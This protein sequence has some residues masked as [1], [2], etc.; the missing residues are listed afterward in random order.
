MPS[1]NLSLSQDPGYHTLADV[2]FFTPSAVEKNSVLENLPWYRLEGNQGVAFY[3]EE[4]T[5]L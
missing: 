1:F 4:T 2:H 5:Q 3:V